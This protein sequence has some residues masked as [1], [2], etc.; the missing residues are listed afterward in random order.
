MM[1]GQARQAFEAIA[2]RDPGCAMAHWGVAMTLFHPLWADPPSTEA[3]ERGAA[4]VSRAR[5]IAPRG[6][7]DRA[8]IDM[9]AAY[10]ESWKERDE[11]ERLA[12]FARAAATLHQR[13]PDDPDATSFHAL[14]LLATAPSDDPTY[15]HQRQA[16]DLLTAVHSQMPRHPGAIHYGIHAHDFPPLAAE[17]VYLADRYD[18]IAPDVPHALHMPSHIF[19]RLG[20]WRKAIEWN[21]RS[22]SAAA[23]QPAGGAR[24]MHY[25]HAM[26][27]LMY[28][29]LQRM[30]DERAAAV[31]RDIDGESRYEIS[32]ASAYA[33]AAIHA[34]MPLE[35][36]DWRRAAELDAKTIRADVRWNELPYARAVLVY[37]RGLG[38]ARS[39][40]LDSARRALAEL[41]AIAAKLQAAGPEAAFWHGRAQVQRDTVA[42]WIAHAMGQ[43]EAASQLMKRAADRE[44]RL[45]KHP[46]MPG[47]VLPARELHGDMLLEQGQFAPAL[48]AYETSLHSSPRR[49]NSFYGAARAADRLGDRERALDYAV[50]LVAMAEPGAERPIVREMRQYLQAR[51]PIEQQARR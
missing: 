49:A 22:A 27:Y 37:T 36:R 25:V 14:G 45:G 24:S 9:A 47:F 50:R 29:Y 28:A 30:D 4:A 16:A 17:G 8:Y 11:R 40:Q 2:S 10:Y 5:Q 41:D 44:D 21:R 43:R 39:D 23:R 15:A 46:I 48:E 19:V 38:A 18:T 35:Q 6:D 31:V 51:G 7:R 20:L 32:P 13:F 34:R 26:D 3:L 1:Y 12:H 33:I 42:A